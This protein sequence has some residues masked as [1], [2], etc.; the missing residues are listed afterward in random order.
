ML[1]TKLP[2][3]FLALH[4]IGGAW[5]LGGYYS[6]ASWVMGGSGLAALAV[7]L[8]ATWKGGKVRRCEGAKVRLA[9]IIC[10]GLL[11]M[12]MAVSLLNE[13]YRSLDTGAGL[14]FLF[15]LHPTWLPSVISAERSGPMI[16]QFC[17]SLAAGLSLLLLPRH[18]CRLLLKLCVGSAVIL[19]L[20]GAALDLIG[21][22]NPLLFFKSVNPSFFASFSYH[23]HWV[24]YA[25]VCFGFA[26]F[27]AT[28]AMR[29]RT[30]ERSDN[31]QIGFYAAA[32]LFLFL[33]LLIVESRA[34]VMVAVFFLIA[35][36]VRLL[37]RRSSFSVARGPFFAA[38]VT[39]LLATVAVLTWQISQKQL[40]RV[41]DRYED[42][43]YSF[44]DPDEEVADFR[45]DSG[46]KIAMD[47]IQEK[48]LLGWGF[49]SYYYSMHIVA[50][51]YLED[52]VSAQYAHNDWLQFIGELGLVGIL[53]LIAPP[54]YGLYRF[55]KSK[56]HTGW[57]TYSLAIILFMA[58]FEF[59]LS[60]PAVMAHFLIGAITVIRFKETRRMGTEER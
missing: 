16:F 9:F 37:I 5:L 56:V 23:N 42:T 18:Q 34:G 11:A 1:R 52:G 49:G 41:G 54:L 26:L 53:L 6:A 21:A 15:K 47:L 22:E 25:T 8:A 4:L 12:L 55:R 43:W 7:A 2:L 36:G 40:D 44:W 39:L 14:R 46:P 48:P 10:W 3:F 17:G 31:N 20:L 28:R 58:L 59:P 19:A 35:A 57:I 60:N 32:V 29:H 30:G 51:D 13:S 50:P 27:L 38:V 45:F 24:A 33:S